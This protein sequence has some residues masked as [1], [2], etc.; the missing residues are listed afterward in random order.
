MIA[1]LFVRPGFSSPFFHHAICSPLLLALHSGKYAEFMLAVTGD[2]SGGR[3][4]ASVQTMTTGLITKTMAV[5]CDGCGQ[6]ASTE[7]I[8]RRLQRLEW[9]TRY[10]PVHIQT[11]LLG[12]VSPRDDN[13]FLYTPHGEFGG[14]ARLV[15]EAAG[16]STKDK[17]REAAHTEFQRAGFFL[18]HV[19]ECPF[20]GGV[21]AGQGLPRLLEQQLPAVLVR[22]RRSLKPKRMALISGAL[23]GWMEK[24]VS[25]QLG[26]ALLLD[27]GKP[28]ALESPDTNQ[29]AARL[30]KAVTE[31]RAN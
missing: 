30:L 5:P 10:R 16:I 23:E 7:H 29:A 12:A 20:E 31:A 25:A 28:F 21:L 22:I 8:G 26:C 15:L 14:E 27:D 18:T 1:I 9:T 2:R 6:A 24:I 11:L 13:E 19:L 3:E 17:T 4:Q